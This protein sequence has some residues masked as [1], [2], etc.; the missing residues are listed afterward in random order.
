MNH[1]ISSAEAEAKN[2]APTPWFT[3]GGLP[4]SESL[5]LSERISRPDFNSLRYEVTV[6][7]PGTYTRSWGNGW[8]LQWVADQEMEEYYCDEYNRETERQEVR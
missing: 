1:F 8:T 2:W 7:D 4:H 6:D 5:K 3:N